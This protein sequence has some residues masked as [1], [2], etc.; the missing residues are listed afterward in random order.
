MAEVYFYLTGMEL[1]G[2]SKRVIAGIAIEFFWCIGLYIL[3]LV[4]FFAR[5]WNILQ[6]IIAC[7]APLLI[8]Y[9]W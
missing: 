8:L 5:D 7:P 9:F 6:L 3:N 2:P 1:V 4:A